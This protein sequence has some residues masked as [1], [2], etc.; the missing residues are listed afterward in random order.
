MAKEL[1]LEIIPEA[2]TEKCIEPCY[3]WAQ[4]AEHAQRCWIFERRADQ[5]VDGE[6]MVK[7]MAAIEHWLFTGEA[8]KV[9]LKEKQKKLKELVREV[10]GPIMRPGG[11]PFD[12]K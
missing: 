9:E 6:Q 1:E 3:P 5:E 8:V 10:V 11:A 4:T 2:A 7:D 12:L